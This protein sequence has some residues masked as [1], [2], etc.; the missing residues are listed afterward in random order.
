MAATK[1]LLKPIQLATDLDT[2]NDLDMSEK[3]IF[4]STQHTS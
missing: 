2:L 4:N 3:V 1:A